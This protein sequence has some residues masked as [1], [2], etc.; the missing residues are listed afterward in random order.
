MDFV[1]YSAARNHLAP[2][3]APAAPRIEG[4]IVMC[5]V[6]THPLM[7]E[8]SG[9]KLVGLFTF[10]TFITPFLHRTYAQSLYRIIRTIHSGTYQFYTIT[11]THNPLLNYLN[12]SVRKSPSNLNQVQSRICSIQCPFFSRLLTLLLWPVVQ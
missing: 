5:H 8:M 6:T 2:A 11:F 1:A 12:S 10:Y 9:I 4:S 3:A 7:P